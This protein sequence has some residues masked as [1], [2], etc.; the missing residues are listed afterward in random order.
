MPTPVY[1][2]RL[3]EA[4]Q[5]NLVDVS[6]LYGAPN[7]SVFLREMVSSL[8]SGDQKRVSEFVTRLIMKMGE[9]L[10]LNLV[11]QAAR[12]SKQSVVRAKRARKGAKHGRPT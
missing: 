11:Q 6:K 9:Q 12:D 4:D 5:K 1:R 7:T 8:C 10:T 3:S 2:F